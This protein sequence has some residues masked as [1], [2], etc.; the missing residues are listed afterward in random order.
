MQPPR[1]RITAISTFMFTREAVRVYPRLMKVPL[2]KLLRTAFRLEHMSGRVRERCHRAAE[3]I[4]TMDF[5]KFMR[6][7]Q[8][9]DRKAQD[10]A[11]LVSSRVIDLEIPEIE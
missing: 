5:Y 2:Q 7:E 3:D 6:L 10:V 11:A 9:V 1:R 4:Q 8:K